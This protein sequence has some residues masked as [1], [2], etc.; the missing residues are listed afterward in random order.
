MSD[1]SELE[2]VMSISVNKRTPRTCVTIPRIL[3]DC[4]GQVSLCK[5]CI[6]YGLLLLYYCVDNGIMTR[7]VSPWPWR[8]L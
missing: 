1:S 5:C 3:V 6:V 2:S 8:W 7:D 4:L